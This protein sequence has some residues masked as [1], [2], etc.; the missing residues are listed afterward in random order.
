MVFFTYKKT[1]KGLEEIKLQKKMNLKSLMSM[2]FFSSIVYSMP[3]EDCI[4]DANIMVELLRAYYANDIK[5]TAYN[6]SISEG[7]VSIYVANN[8]NSTCPKSMMEMGDL[9]A[10]VHSSC[11]T[12]K[13]ISKDTS[14]YPQ[15]IE[16]VYCRCNGPCLA[17]NG[18]TSP[19]HFCAPVAIKRIVLRKVGC[20][21]GKAAY[22]PEWIQQKVGCQCLYTKRD[23]FKRN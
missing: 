17:P 21:N 15:N 12:Y 14:R 3:N 4:T 8:E 23:T 9:T 16:E 19:Y 20:Q 1:K 7:G 5:P 2:I 11:P 18:K 13:G 10:N 6:E 22:V